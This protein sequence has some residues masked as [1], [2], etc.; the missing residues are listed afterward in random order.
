MSPRRAEWLAA[1][2]G[3]GLLLI[4]ALAWYQ[5]ADGSSLS[6][7]QAFDVTDVVLA[8][9]GATALLFG[10]AGIARPTAAFSVPASSVI[11]GLGFVAVVLV[12]IRLVDPPMDLS[13]EPGAWLGLAAC[14]AITIAGWYGMG[15]DPESA[16]TG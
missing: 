15:E 16:S 13:V 3:L 5:A 6:A 10:I 12:V 8:L 2:S 1:L 11:A 7:W 4:S 14:L 9:A